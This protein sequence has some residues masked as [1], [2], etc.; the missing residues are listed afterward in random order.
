MNDKWYSKVYTVK[1]NRDSR[2]SQVIT[3]VWFLNGQRHRD[4][5]LPAL[6][7]YSKGCLRREWCQ[8]GQL[9]REGAPASLTT[10]IK[11][12]MVLAEAW[13]RADKLHREDG[14][15][16]ATMWDR[17]TGKIP[18]LEYAEDGVYRS[19]GPALTYYS[20]R[21]GRVIEQ[22]YFVNGMLSERKTRTRSLRRSRKLEP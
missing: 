16:A 20:G 4:D 22:Y 18:K 8:H 3:E 10:D 9:H 15:A 7:N 17:G 2:T 14:L 6:T 12:G 19:D 13:F 5:D 11:T 21:S 1:I